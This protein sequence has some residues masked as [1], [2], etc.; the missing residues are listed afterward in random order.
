M[1]P[2]LQSLIFGLC[3]PP[4]SS[5]RSGVFQSHPTSFL[6]G[7]LRVLSDQLPCRSWV[8]LA[9]IYTRLRLLTIA[10]PA[11]ELGRLFLVVPNSGF[12]PRIRVK[13]FFP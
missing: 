9:V 3:L 10:L 2:F 7:R 5:F 1:Q 13:F 11:V 8:L 6:F 12:L 4:L